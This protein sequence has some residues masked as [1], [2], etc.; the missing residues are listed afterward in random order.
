MQNSE[1]LIRTERVFVS[2][3]IRKKAGQNSQEVIDIPECSKVSVSTKQISTLNVTRATG[4]PDLV[5]AY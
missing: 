4:Q 1:I 5:D 2:L 3:A